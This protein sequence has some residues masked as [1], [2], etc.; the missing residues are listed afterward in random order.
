M[1]V[2][3]MRKLRLRRIKWLAQS[4]TVEV[5]ELTL[6]LFYGTMRPFRQTLNQYHI[7]GLNLLPKHR[8]N[9]G[10]IF[11][12]MTCAVPWP[13]LQVPWSDLGPV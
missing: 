4:Q 10:D 2:I 13:S 11:T 12:C 9:P 5:T 8:T 6:T 1:P 7:K 3:P